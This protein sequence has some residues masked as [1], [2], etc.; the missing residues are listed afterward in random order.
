MAKFFGAPLKTTT[1]FF[2]DRERVIKAVGRKTASAMRHIGGTILKTAKRS[3]RKPTKNK[4]HSKPGQPVRS[5]TGILK[6]TIF[7]EFEPRTQTL[8]VGPKKLPIKSN[9]RPT[10]R[11]SVPELLEKGGKA[12]A[13]KPTYIRV[14][15]RKKSR[16]M[17]QQIWKRI[18]AGSRT[19]R[20]R[21][22]MA[23][24]YKK[25]VKLPQLRKAF[26]VIGFN[27]R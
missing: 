18:E 12:Q 16:R 25:I 1:K 13:D 11:R 24:A 19:Y 2:F 7:F 3:I 8:I 21:P 27:T 5:G 6:R 10:N 14:G 9:V 4:P 17:K 23:L 20:P 26:G 22:T 15:N